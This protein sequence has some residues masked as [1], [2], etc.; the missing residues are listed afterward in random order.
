VVGFYWAPPPSSPRAFRREGDVFEDLGTL[1]GGNSALAYDVSDDGSVVVGFGTT[2]SGGPYHAFVW[3]RSDE[4]DEMLDI[5]TLTGCGQMWGNGVNGDG[6]VVV[7]VCDPG[8]AYRWTSDGG[9]LLFL[10]TP[11]GF[12]ASSPIAVNSDGSVV[13]GQTYSVNND[14]RAFRWTSDEGI[15]NLGTLPGG[16]Y[17]DA[18]AVSGDVR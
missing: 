1:P 8:G 2:V 6:S 7:G 3:T 16:T 9:P 12:S 18:Y 5:A 10:G 17:S 4:G 11:P 13:V 14:A 15:V